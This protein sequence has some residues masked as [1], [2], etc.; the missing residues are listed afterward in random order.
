MRPGCEAEVLQI[1]GPKALGSFPEYD[2]P[3][4]PV[5]YGIKIWLAE[6]RVMQKRW[7]ESMA[8]FQETCHRVWTCDRYQ[9]DRPDTS[10][11]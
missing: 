1:S 8:A 6:H 2:D 5:P 7:A 4:D 9:A 11:A 3:S 10:F